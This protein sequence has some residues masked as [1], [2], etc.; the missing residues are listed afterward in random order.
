MNNP[1][2]IATTVRAITSL[3]VDPQRGEDDVGD[4]SFMDCLV[5]IV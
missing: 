3:V 4:G 1:A 2:M 5:V